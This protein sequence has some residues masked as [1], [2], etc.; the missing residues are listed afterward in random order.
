[1]VSLSQ[2]AGKIRQQLPTQETVAKVARETTR[3]GSCAAGHAAII[4]ADW[5]LWIKDNE[6]FTQE[7]TQAHVGAMATSAFIQTF[8]RGYGQDWLE[9]KLGERYY[10]DYLPEIV[11]NAVPFAIMAGTVCYTGAP[12]DTTDAMAKFLF[13]G[14]GQ[15]GV[16]KLAFVRER[17]DTRVVPGPEVRVE[18][19][20]PGPERIV[21][22]NHFYLPTTFVVTKQ[23]IDGLSENYGG[24]NFERVPFDRSYDHSAET[25]D[26]AVPLS[27]GLQ[28]KHMSGE[29][30]LKGTSPSTEWSTLRKLYQAD[31]DAAWAP[32]Q[33]EAGLS[34]KTVSVEDFLSPKGMIKISLDF[35]GKTQEE[36]TRMLDWVKR[37]SENSGNEVHSMVLKGASDATLKELFGLD[38]A[39]RTP[40]RPVLKG[41]CTLKLQNSEFNVDT[42]VNVKA[43]YEN[44]VAFDLAGSE[45]SVTGGVRS[46]SNSGSDRLKPT[47]DGHM[48]D[49]EGLRTDAAGPGPQPIDEVFHNK[50]ARIITNASCIVVNPDGSSNIVAQLV[51]LDKHMTKQTLVYRQKIL[52]GDEELPELSIDPTVFPAASFIREVN[53][54]RGLHRMPGF[55]HFIETLS[56]T[57][58]FAVSWDFSGSDIQFGDFKNILQIIKPL[59][60][61]VQECEFVFREFSDLESGGTKDDGITPSTIMLI[62][63]EWKNAVS[64]SKSIDMRGSRIQQSKLPTYV[65]QDLDEFVRRVSDNPN[66][67]MEALHEHDQELLK[68]MV[69]M[70]L[71]RNNRML[72][73]YTLPNGKGGLR[74]MRAPAEHLTPPTTPAPV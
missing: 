16:H 7:M 31:V 74:R 39:K 72:V 51:N 46:R 35:E 43:K 45:I 53:Y 25:D 66:S 28:R 1:M 63:N 40:E 20:V 61:T 22:E 27:N 8:I 52:S 23:N 65:G 67:A 34:E 5:T 30:A 71:T 50:L 18:V 69:D 60:I 73:Q 54:F 47:V 68:Y 6:S 10:L 38:P 9:K 13:A 29:E 4:A 2:I 36:S 57:Y 55:K 19:E 62:L 48:V 56:K 17:V 3:L 33:G 58:P 12:F 37:W 32:Y 44:I 21:I 59:H 11:F 64:G 41:L 42:L 14:L 24:I 15:L 70:G 49:D 26:R